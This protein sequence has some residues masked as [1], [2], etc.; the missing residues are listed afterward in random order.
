M[1]DYKIIDFEVHADNRGNLCSLSN[2]KE[3]PFEV[4]RIYYTWDMPYDVI[5]GGH[6]HKK[7]DE[8]MVCLSGSCDFVLDDGKEKV[9]V[10]LDK[11]NKGL[12][13]KANLWRDFRNFS[14][15]CVVVLIA[16][17]LYDT[18]DYIRDYNEYLNLI[19]NNE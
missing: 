11:P 6:A 5:R 2:N 1:K 13:I 14:K 4:K 16:S 8:V 17:E 3:I 12:Y 10:T 18:E 7:L 19:N 15:D 9:T